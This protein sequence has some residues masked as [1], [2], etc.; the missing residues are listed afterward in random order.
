MPD[1]SPS[2]KHPAPRAA[3]TGLRGFLDSVWWI[4]AIG[5]GTAIILALIVLI[6]LVITGA[7]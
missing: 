4:P 3:R 2:L 7:R 6:H 1:R 5:Y